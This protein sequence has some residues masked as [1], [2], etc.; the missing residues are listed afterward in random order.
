M[1]FNIVYLAFGLAS[2]VYAAPVLGQPVEISV[3]H[4][5]PGTCDGN[6]HGDQALC[7]WVPFTFT[8]MDRK[9]PVEPEVDEAAKHLVAGLFRTGA[10]Y[11]LYRHPLA[12]HANNKF[13]D[14]MDVVITK[15]ISFSVEAEHLPHRNG[16]FI[17][18]VKAEFSKQNGKWVLQENTIVGYL[19]AHDGEKV[20]W[21]E[22]GNQVKVS[23][24]IWLWS[25]Y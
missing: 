23:L 2:I 25:P 1:H 16:P 6:G 17:G 19:E 5:T 8:N 24:P 22:A 10:T 4:S 11:D 3:T 15:G 9:D 18:H 12:A 7:V 21:V 13:T 14:S 20:L